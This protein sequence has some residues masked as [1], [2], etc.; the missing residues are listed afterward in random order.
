[1]KKEWIFG[2]D[3]FYAMNNMTEGG[4][5]FLSPFPTTL[6][7]YNFHRFQH[8]TAT[9]FVESLHLLVFCRWGFLG[10]FWW[11]IS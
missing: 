11:D 8:C 5:V 3:E 2:Q 9:V 1:M 6:V 4:K 10:V 7:A